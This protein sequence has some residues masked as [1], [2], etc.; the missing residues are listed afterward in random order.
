M[1]SD[2]NSLRELARIISGDPTLLGNLLRVANSAFYGA[3]S[4]RI[5]NLDR[6]VTLVGL[7]GIRS[8]IATS[9]MH[10]VMANGGGCFA[11]FPDNVWEH[12]QIAAD[13]AE[14]HAI[15]LERRDGFNARLLAL[16]HGLAVN[17]VF[18][19]V[20]DEALE[21]GDATAKPAVTHLLEQWVTP[22]ASRIATSWE[23]PEEV[24]TALTA[25]RV[26]CALARSL[27][28]G[29]LA[30]SQLVLVQRHQI[31]EFAAR[32]FVLAGDTR[33]TQTDRLWTRLV[34]ANQPR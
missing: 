15:H 31:R 24:Q 34:L 17:T 6:A 25:S 4:K 21:T 32:A 7:N 26:D 3:R 30:A 13:A 28:F 12:T 9:L 23:L 14:L 1:H 29:R 5:A 19:I 10:P 2:T 27:F 8:V 33:R 11:K 18:R 22:I 16:V 20:R